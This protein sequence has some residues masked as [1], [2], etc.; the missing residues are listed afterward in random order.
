MIQA[1]ETSLGSTGSGGDYLDDLVVIQGLATYYAF[2]NDVAKA[3]EW[4]ER[5]F[6]LSPDAIDARILRS[7]LFDEVRDDPDD[8]DD[9]AGFSET[10]FRVQRQARDLVQAGWERTRSDPQ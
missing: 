6:E 7:A 3:T 10:L 1:A 2:M 5:A 9:D 4:V 8:P